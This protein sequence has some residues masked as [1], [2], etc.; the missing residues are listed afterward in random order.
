MY[1]GLREN[2]WLT[3]WI[4][5][6]ATMRKV[7][8]S[9]QEYIL[10][11]IVALGSLYS[12]LNSFRIPD[13]VHA[14][15][16]PNVAFTLSVGALFAILAFYIQAAFLKL[17]GSWIGGEASYEDIQAAVAW[18]RIPLAWGLLLWIP[19]LAAFGERAFPQG[20]MPRAYLYGFG[21]F[22]T[23]SHNGL[24]EVL[25]FNIF[26]IL[27]AVIGIWAFIIL[28]NCLA[29]VQGFSIGQAFVNVVLAFGIVIVPI[30]VALL[31]FSIVSMV[32]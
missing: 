3:I 6:R 21:N 4:R 7:L 15:T 24:A 23:A 5:P 29:E 9:K 16:W 14:G 19:R 30:A 18:S 32:P 31:S 27:M 22:F 25:L 17:S 1:A 2:P 13:G 28:L 8:H 11:V 10:L 20:S 12:N 26:G